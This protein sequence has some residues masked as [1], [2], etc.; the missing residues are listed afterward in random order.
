MTTI[1]NI[2]WISFHHVSIF[3]LVCMMT[4]SDQNMWCTRTTLDEIYKVYV[5]SDCYI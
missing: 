4:V 2:C 1:D 3:V 5:V